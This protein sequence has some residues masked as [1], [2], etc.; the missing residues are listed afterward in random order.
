MRYSLV[1]LVCVV[2]LWTGAGAQAQ[3]VP[4]AM[5]IVA[6]ASVATSR[7]LSVARLGRA[8]GTSLGRYARGI[9]EPLPTTRAASAGRH[10]G[11]GGQVQLAGWASDSAQRSYSA[12]LGGSRGSLSAPVVSVRL[13]PL[14]SDMMVSFLNTAGPRQVNPQLGDLNGLWREVTITLD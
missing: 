8:T 1:A 10:G 7:A 5:R 14:Y 13:V 4:G 12:D 9:V 2:T 6:D 3:V 11:L